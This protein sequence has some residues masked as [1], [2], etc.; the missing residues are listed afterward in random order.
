MYDLEISDSS[1]LEVHNKKHVFEYSID[2][3]KANPIEA[4][5]A[6]LSACAGVYAIKA[7]KK[8]NLS[9]MGIRISGKPYLEKTNPLMISK[10]LTSISFPHGWTEENKALVIG[11]IQKCAVKE[12]ISKGVEIEF[13]TEETSSPLQ[14]QETSAIL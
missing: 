8:M 14:T 4:T 2:G 6:A 13:L 7:C 5:Y 9:P 3:S 1:K 10:W 12:M 11:E